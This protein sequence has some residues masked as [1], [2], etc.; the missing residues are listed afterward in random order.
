MLLPFSI[1]S[2]PLYRGTT[3]RFGGP[4]ITYSL[5]YSY[6]DLSP[7]L[8]RLPFSSL[9]QVLE[10]YNSECLACKL[11]PNLLG[12]YLDRFA[13]CARYW[14]TVLPTII[15]GQI[16]LLF[17]MNRSPYINVISVC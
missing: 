8:S 10:P 4:R 6:A 13:A 16:M 3:L 5:A 2:E 11:F 7:F 1:N 14:V 15:M 12:A 17:L 9:A